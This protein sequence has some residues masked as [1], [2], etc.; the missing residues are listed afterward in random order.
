[1]TLEN[2]GVLLTG[3][4]HFGHALALDLAAGGAD[5]AIVHRDSRAA[6]EAA[7][8]A[9]SGLGRR[10][11]LLQADLT[12]PDACQRAVDDAARTFGRLD[13]LVNMVS[14]G[15]RVSLERLTPERW[16][17]DLDVNLRAGYACA[18][19]AIPHMR[20]LGGGRIINFSDWR[21]A[22]GRPQSRG[23]LPYYVA[24]R[25]VMAFTE[26]LA[27]EVARDGILVNAIA[28]GPMI[29]TEDRG[30]E[31]ARQVSDETPVGRWGG[32]DDIAK[33]VRFLIETEFVT[34]ETIRVDG[35]QHLR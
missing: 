27:L 11:L 1:M 23:F 32:A 31:Q 24:T 13:V 21:A 3:A 10:A 28:P 26:A 22:S 8:A 14:H 25:G 12:Q 16:R 33:T 15:E 30:V 4:R 6:A 29:A 17:A 35:G 34:G 2:R 7:A 9:V 20:R 19:A 5:V 18:L